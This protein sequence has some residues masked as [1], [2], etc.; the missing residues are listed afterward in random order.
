MKQLSHICPPVIVS[1]THHKTPITSVVLPRSV[2][3]PQF[4]ISLGSRTEETVTNEAI[5]V[6]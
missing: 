2:Y 6:K 5:S 1:R 3:A 4:L